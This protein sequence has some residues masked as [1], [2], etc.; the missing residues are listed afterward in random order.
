MVRVMLIR[1]GTTESNL[2]DARMA[3]SV[4]KGQVSQETAPRVMR[5]QLEQAPEDEQT[6]DTHLSVRA[7]AHRPS[8]ASPLSRCRLHHRLTREEGSSRCGEPVHVRT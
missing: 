2:R 7:H 5:E 8:A 6:G 4:A 3:I 1:H